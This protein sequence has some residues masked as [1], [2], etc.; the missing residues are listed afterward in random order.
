MRRTSGTPPCLRASRVSPGPRAP[1]LLWRRAPVLCCLAT[2]STDGG[3]ACFVA[4]SI[5]PGPG[6]VGVG[7][8]GLVWGVLVFGGVCAV[9]VVRKRQRKGSSDWF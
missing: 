5:G 6:M 9:Q 4:A 2:C 7:V 1:A 8:I 3:L